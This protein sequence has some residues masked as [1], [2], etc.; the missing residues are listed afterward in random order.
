MRIMLRTLFLVLVAA[1]AGTLASAAAHAAGDADANPAV[2]KLHALFESEWQRGL[3]EN[4]VGASYLGDRTYNDRLPDVSMEA[5]QAS[6]EADKAALQKLESIDRSALPGDEQLNYDL[7]QWQLEDQIEGFKFHGYL[8]PLNQRGGIQTFDETQQSIRLATEKDYRDWVARLQAFGTYM[9]QTI[10]LMKQGIAEGMVMPKVV[11]QRIPDQIARQ[12]VDEPQDS[13]FYKPFAERPEGI[14][15]EAWSDIHDQG[16]AAIRDVVLPAY[17]RFQTFFDKTYL[18]ACRDTVGAWD[19]PN[20]REYYQYLAR[21]FTTT[22]MTPEEIHKVGLE[23]VKRIHAQMEEI[24]KEVGFDGSFQDFLHYLR[25]DP[26]FYY[27]DPQE[28]FDAYKVKAKTVDPHLVDLF[29]HLPRTPYGVKPI[30]DATAPDTTTAYYMQPAADGSRAGYYYVNLY[31]PETRPKYEMDVLTTH[32]A[33]PGHHLQI[34][35]AMELKDLPKFRRFGGE[36]AFVEGWALYSES[37]CEKVGLCQ[38]P[39]TRFGQLT[40]DMWRA[41]RLVVDT[42][43]HYMKWSRQD[44]IDY[45]KKNAA[46]TDQDIVNEIDRYIA[47]P[48]Q[49]LAY[50]IGQLR[51]MALKAKAKKELGG[52]FDIKA[53]HDTVLGNGAV[54]LKVLDRIVNDWIAEQKAKESS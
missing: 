33:V 49:A 32:E 20:G 13:P 14:G 42:G 25:T 10:A 40:Y 46:K 35:L 21:H 27:K 43:M 45:F 9:D 18:P 51:I 36:T 28:L 48:G 39:Y 4:P 22:D 11:M 15:E 34:A 38:D 54:P 16:V 7:F 5:I 12:V 1:G 53:F 44:A 37:L 31:K 19:L 47:W 24:I 3:K 2:E 41:V 23:E 50:K 30:P 52:D 17:K 6:H 8:M 26:K 29:G